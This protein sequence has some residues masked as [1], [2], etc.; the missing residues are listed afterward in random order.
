MLGIGKLEIIWG[1][2]GHF[3]EAIS[4]WVTIEVKTCFAQ[5]FSIRASLVALFGR[6]LANGRS[7]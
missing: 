3:V 5:K 6:A 7:R 4:Q 2:S 1:W